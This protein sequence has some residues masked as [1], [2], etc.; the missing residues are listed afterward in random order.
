[1]ILGGA[2][3][4]TSKKASKRTSKK[5]VRRRAGAPDLEGGLRRATSKKRVTSRKVASKKPAVRRRAGAPELE[6]GLRASSRKVASKKR[7]A[8]RKVA[9]KKVAV[10]KRVAA[11]RR[12]GNI[13]GDI[14]GAVTNPIGTIAHLFGAGGDDIDDVKADIREEKAESRELAR[15]LKKAFDIVAHGIEKTYRKQGASAAEAKRQVND[16]RKYQLLSFEASRLRTV[17]EFVRVYVD[18]LLQ[19]SH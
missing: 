3:R 13:I 11:P 4:A 9:S 8:S 16:E 17:N 1:M 12:G 7:V 18:S 10:K 5:P 19:A 6:G 2:R 15:S 14:L